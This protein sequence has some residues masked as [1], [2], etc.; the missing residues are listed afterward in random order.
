MIDEG[1]TG[2]TRTLL[3][4]F[5]FFRKLLMRLWSCLSGVVRETYEFEKVTCA[6]RIVFSNP[7]AFHAGKSNLGSGLILKVL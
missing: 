6:S 4:Y 2:E 7:C 5:G 1:V 3:Q